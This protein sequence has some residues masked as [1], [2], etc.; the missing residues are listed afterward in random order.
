MASKFNTAD[1][2]V[3]ATLIAELKTENPDA[4]VAD[5]QRA[6][7]DV[8]DADSSRFDVDKF[9]AA[10]ERMTTNRLEAIA[11]R[12]LAIRVA[13]EQ[14]QQDDPSADYDPHNRR[15]VEGVDQQ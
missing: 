8:F 15:I 7:E 9:R 6:I 12:R 10:I 4:T 5:M 13:Y 2:N 3:F 1:Y 11:R 14:Q